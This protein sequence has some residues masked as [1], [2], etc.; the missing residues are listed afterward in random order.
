M[1]MNN[2]LDPEEQYSFLEERIKDDAF[3]IRKLGKKALKMLG[4]GVVFGFAVC[5]GFFALK[6]WAESVFQTEEQVE[7]PQDNDASAEAPIQTEGTQELQDLTI[8]DYEKLN[9]AV[10]Q[11]AG[12]SK[13][14]VAYISTSETGGPGAAGV[15]V[16]DNGKELLIFTTSYALE[17]AKECRV[18]LIDDASYVG[19]VKQICNNLCIGIVSVAKSDISES[20]MAR[21]AIAEFGNSNVLSQGEVLIALGNL[22]GHEDEVSYG[23]SASVSQSVNHADGDY[24][25]LVTD[26]AGNKNSNGFLFDINGKLIGII[27][28]QL[29]SQSSVLTAYGI[30]TLKSEIELMTNDKAVPYT[31][32][33]GT[34]VTKEIS[35]QKGIPVGV[36]VTEVEANSPAMTAGVQSGDVITH[37]GGEEIFS[38]AGYR[39]GLI[40]KDVG[41]NLYLKGQRHGTE[42]YVNIDFNVIVGEK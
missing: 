26:M 17:D 1:S 20:T 2:Q 28:S 3:D 25:I 41:S 21:L 12:T 32:I 29:S 10:R 34:M 15:I 35:K 31:G 22:Y 9:L 36:Y 8:A 33:V 16:A 30:S 27:D 37:I 42:S 23:V 6:P 4:K 5:I 40:N 18:K 13:K 38:M 39:S 19:T 7:I 11:V 14:S 24:S